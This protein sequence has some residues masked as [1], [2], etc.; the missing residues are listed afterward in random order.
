VLADGCDEGPFASAL[1][2]FVTQTRPQAVCTIASTWGRQVIAR[3]AARLN[4]GLITDAVDL[5]LENHRLVGL[6]T[7]PGGCEIEARSSSEV[8]L[9]SLSLA[10]LPWQQRGQCAPRTERLAVAGDP[11][12]LTKTTL[13]NDNWESLSRA[14]TVVGIGAGVAERDLPQLDGLLRA[15]RAELAATRKVTDQGWLPHSRQV[16]I[17]GRSISPTLYIAIGLS[18]N[19]NHMSGVRRS[20]TILAINEDPT[21]PVF[22]ECDIGIVANWHEVVDLLAAQIVVARHATEPRQQGANQPCRP[23]S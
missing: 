8:Q 16:G 13:T 2:R 12:V 10:D 11:N 1:S 22:D 14:S 6:K 15:T 17:T 4:A 7:A 20:T 18:G 5:I 9:F 21:A 23:A 3:L 19:P